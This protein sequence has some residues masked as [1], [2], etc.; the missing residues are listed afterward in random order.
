MTALLDSSVLLDFLRGH[1][2]AVRLIDSLDD[3]P[4]SSEI[5]RVELLQ[6]LRP[7]EFVDAAT[8]AA[9]IEWVPVGNR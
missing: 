4:A 2:G 1:P 5:C 8:L 7:H 9:L 3:P 6:G